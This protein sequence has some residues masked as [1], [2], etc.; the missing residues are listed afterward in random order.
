ME[1]KR[2]KKG[3][4]TEYLIWLLISL[5]VL[6]VLMITIFIIKGEGV[7]LIEKI[8]ALFR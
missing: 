1:Y 4:A 2:G 5:A 8:K 7:S 3:I 6:V